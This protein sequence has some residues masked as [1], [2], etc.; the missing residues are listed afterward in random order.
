MHN[1]QG[2]LDIIVSRY[3]PI[4]NLYKR[5][6]DT[7]KHIGARKQNANENRKDIP[8]L[9]LVHA[10]KPYSCKYFDNTD[11]ISQNHALI[12]VDTCLGHVKNTSSGQFNSQQHKMH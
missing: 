4:V 1:T 7:M 9:L 11:S 2:E 6:C 5:K 10:D 12:N 3:T 8:Y